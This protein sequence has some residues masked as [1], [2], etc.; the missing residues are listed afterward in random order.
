MGEVKLKINRSEA[1]IAAKVKVANGYLLCSVAGKAARGFQVTGRLSS[2]A[3]S[4]ALHMV[5]QGDVIRAGVLKKRM[6]LAA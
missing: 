1:V 3:I 4:E 6:P 2:Q 5:G